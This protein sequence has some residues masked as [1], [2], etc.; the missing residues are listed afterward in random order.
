MKKPETME[1][2]YRIYPEIAFGAG[3]VIG[4]YVVVVVP[5]RGREPGEMTTTLG[6]G[7]VLRSHTVLDA[8]NVIGDNFQTGHGALGRGGNVTSEKGRG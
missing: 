5:P 1:P 3:A 8:G 6:A 4:D 2:T 7:A